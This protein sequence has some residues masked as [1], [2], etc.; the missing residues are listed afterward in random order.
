MVD[1]CGVIVDSCRVAS[2]G[3]KTSVPVVC[4]E[5]SVLFESARV[6]T[7]LC[8]DI[9]CV[10][11]QLSPKNEK[12]TRVY[13][14]N[15]HQPW[16]LALKSDCD[17]GEGESDGRIVL[18]GSEAPF[19]RMVGRIV[20]HGSDV[21]FSRMGGELCYTGPRYLFLGWGVNCVTRVRGTF[22]SDGVNCV[23]D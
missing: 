3:G 12:R 16:P 15:V 22:F 1:S 10:A 4:C 18:H 8:G 19:S 13:T 11:F 21:P 9:C 17:R 2:A 23:T 7:C 20:L 14:K 5:R 6:Y